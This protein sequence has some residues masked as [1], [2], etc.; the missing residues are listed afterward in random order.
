MDIKKLLEIRDMVLSD[1]AEFIPE[2]YSPGGNPI[3]PDSFVADH[4]LGRTLS[5][6]RFK[7]TLRQRRASY[8]LQSIGFYGIVIT[9]FVGTPAG[10]YPQE[11]SIEDRHFSNEVRTYSQYLP[12]KESKY[13]LS[14]LPDDSRPLDDRERTTLLV[15]IAALAKEAR[16]PISQP[17]K[18]A[19]LIAKI[20]QEMGASVSKRAI[21]EKLKLID[22]ALQSR[23]RS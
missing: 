7:M 10:F 4:E 15:I 18:A 9:P 8:L 12:D 6:T 13:L 16:V 19:D 17:S 20:T 22:G 3:K 1:L 23:T 11:R 5:A 2:S 14:L 21:E